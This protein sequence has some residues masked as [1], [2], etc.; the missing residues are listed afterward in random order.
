MEERSRLL[1]ERLVKA[2]E[3]SEAA[4]P[5]QEAISAAE[6]DN[7]TLTAQLK[8]F[9]NRVSVLEEELEEARS[10]AEAD[11]EGWKTRLNKSKASEK[12]F[13][14]RE[15]EA[16]EEVKKAERT[17]HGAK[18]RIQEME[19]ALKE[20]KGLLEVARADIEGMRGEVAV[21]RTAQ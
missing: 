4:A 5:R 1:E 12:A 14:D 15:R 20:N 2:R 9:Q 6:I 11:A 18:T 10:Q 8:H 17:A 16:R 7:E 13:A 3:E 19:N 21:S